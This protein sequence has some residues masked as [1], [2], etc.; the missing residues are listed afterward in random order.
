MKLFN[1]QKCPTSLHF[2]FF[3]LVFFARHVAS[4]SL[5]LGALLW[6]GTLPF[7]FSLVWKLFCFSSSFFFPFFF[8]LTRHDFYFLI[9]W[10]IAFF[11]FSCLS[12]FCFNWSSFF[13]KCVGVNLYK[14][15]FSIS[16]FFH[17]QP[18]KNER[19]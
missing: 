13:N 3:F 15:I 6:V 9:N 10:V 8:C 14:F 18:N 4:L 19:N 2:L 7:F 5:S 17:S 1:G 12:L 16:P 11:F